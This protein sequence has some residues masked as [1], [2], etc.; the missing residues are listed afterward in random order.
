MQL[1]ALR[2]P[3]SIAGPVLVGLVLLMNLAWATPRLNH[4]L[5][6][7][8]G[9]ILQV[10]PYVIL[11]ASQTLLACALDHQHVLGFLRILVCARTL[12]LVLAA[13]L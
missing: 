8:T 5:C 12:L 11:V 9:K 6:T 7:A 1:T 4:I 13:A 3:K 2:S 10:L